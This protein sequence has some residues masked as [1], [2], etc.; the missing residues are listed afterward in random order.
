MDSLD[1]REKERHVEC[2]NKKI[3]SLNLSKKEQ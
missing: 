2:E 3:K 1:R